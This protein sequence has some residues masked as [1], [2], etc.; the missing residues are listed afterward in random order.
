MSFLFIF[1]FNCHFSDLLYLI[2]FS[3]LQYWLQEW[4]VFMM[5]HLGVWTL[6]LE[7]WNWME[8]IKYM[9]NS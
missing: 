8:C 2:Y 3:P 6:L 9:N 7:Q 1:T 4:R 5:T